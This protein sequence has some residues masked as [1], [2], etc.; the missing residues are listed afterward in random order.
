MSLITLFT[1]GI[2][3]WHTARMLVKWQYFTYLWTQI[4]PYF[5]EVTCKLKNTD[6]Q[7]LFNIDLTFFNQFQLY[8][9]LL[10]MDRQ[11]PNYN[12]GSHLTIIRFFWQEY[13]LLWSLRIKKLFK[14]LLFV[15]ILIVVCPCICV[16][17]WGEGGGILHD[18]GILPSWVML[19]CF[20]A[21][22]I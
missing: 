1:A 17:V 19:F 3:L 16:C 10:D 7:W 4:P 2:F 11:Y 12:S 15:Y 21:K 22:S 9:W 6:P 8:N 5:D 13:L 14:I 20:V 18:W